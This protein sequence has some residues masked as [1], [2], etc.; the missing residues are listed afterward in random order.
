MSAAEAYG[1]A[2]PHPARAYGRTD[3]KLNGQLPRAER[4]FAKSENLGL[5]PE[6]LTYYRANNAVYDG[7]TPTR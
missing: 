1:T 5:S 2:A 7:D 6:D 3:L 4:L